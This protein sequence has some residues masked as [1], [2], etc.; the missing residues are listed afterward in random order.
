MGIS[1]APLAATN[2]GLSGYPS[3]IAGTSN[4]FTVT[5]YDPYGNVATGYT[6]TLSFTSSD[7]QATLPTNY[8]FVAADNG[9][10]TFS[11]T[12]ATAGSQ[13]I[14]ATD[15]SNSSLTA[16]Q[17][18]ITVTPSVA[19]H[20]G[21]GAP[22]SVKKGV[23]FNATVTALD[24][25]GNVATGYRGTVQF[26]SS[27][28]LAKLPANYT[29]TAADNG[30]HTFLVT[31]NTTGT[32]SLTAKDTAKKSTITG[33]DPSIVVGAALAQPLVQGNL[34]AHAASAHTPALFNDEE[35]WQE[36]V[37]SLLETDPSKRLP[38]IT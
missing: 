27:D 30:V 12:L 23:A 4:S 26:T 29:F 14:T 31:L 32:Q 33:T 11:A 36:L 9:A 6:G 25:Y 18:G 34:P 37:A 22:S 21:I 1:L 24:A 19:T 38:W 17:S 13:S 16:T 5:A 35:L 20:L 28:R 8:T 2:L 10:H 3:T 15:I 7:P